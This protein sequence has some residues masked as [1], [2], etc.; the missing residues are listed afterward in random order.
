MTGIK[1]YNKPAFDAAASRLR[2]LGHTVYS[3]PELDAGDYGRSWNSYMRRDFELL[4]SGKVDMVAVLPFWEWSKGALREVV[5]AQ[6]IGMPVVD[7][8]TME[9]IAEVKICLISE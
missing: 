3:P 9:P 6:T 7:A 2:A 4:L 5:L 1:D 8:E